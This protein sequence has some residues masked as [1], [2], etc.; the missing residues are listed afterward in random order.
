MPSDKP[1]LRA[2]WRSTRNVR[3]SVLAVCALLVFVLVR[4]AIT[5]PLSYMVASAYHGIV[6][7]QTAGI[8]LHFI[9]LVYACSAFLLI[10]LCMHVVS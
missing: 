7:P 4:L 6:N 9:V 8:C 10:A 2:W 3:L 5:M 1:S